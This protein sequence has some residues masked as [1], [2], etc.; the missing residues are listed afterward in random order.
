[1]NKITVNAGKICSVEAAVGLRYSF[2]RKIHIQNASR[3]V[4]WVTHK[5]DSDDLRKDHLS[6]RQSLYSPG[7]EMSP[8]WFRKRNSSVM[9]SF[10]VM[11]MNSCENITKSHYYNVITLYTRLFIGSYRWLLQ[12]CAGNWVK[13]SPLKQLHRAT[14]HNTDQPGKYRKKLKLNNEVLYTLRTLPQIILVF[15]YLPPWAHMKS[16]FVIGPVNKFMIKSVKHVQ[17]PNF[18]AIANSPNKVRYL[19]Y[20]HHCSTF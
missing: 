9:N 14:P 17:M 2:S 4:T 5:I 10:H 12:S 20:V 13:M 11:W 18:L 19:K 16:V 3:S 8:N 6:V 1:M 15:Y 7:L